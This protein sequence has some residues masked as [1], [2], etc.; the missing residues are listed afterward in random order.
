MTSGILGFRADLANVSNGFYWFRFAVL[1][2]L[3]CYSNALIATIYKKKD[4]R[5]DCGNHCGISLLSIPGKILAKL[6]LNRMKNFS[7]EV[8]SEGQCGF[9]AGQFTTDMIFT[10][11]QLQE[12]A[13]K[14]QQSLVVGFI[15]FSKAFGTVD[16]VTLW[17]VLELYGCPQKINIVKLFHDNMTGKVV[18]G[19]DISSPFNIN[20]GVK[21]G[22]MLAPTHFTLYLAAVLETT[23][24]NL[25]EGVYIRTRKDGKLFNLYRLKEST[26]TKEQCV[27]E[28]LYADVSALVA[29]DPVERQEIVDRIVKPTDN[30]GQFHIPG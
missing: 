19:G 6:I 13:I 4:E 30:N 20:H 3:C 2:F 22:C 9:R 5:S 17:K 26:K 28:L 25:K 18:V 24:L 1:L 27:R 10:L 21:Q 23:S 16:R 8:L 15:V 12:N 7:E 11:R 29:T 14:Q